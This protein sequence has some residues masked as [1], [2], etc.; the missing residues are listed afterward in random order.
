MEVVLKQTD[1]RGSVIIL[2]DDGWEYHLV[3]TF[4]GKLRGG[5]IH[6]EG[7]WNHVVK[8]DVKFIFQYDK[9]VE[10][11]YH[12]GDVMQIPAGVPHMSQSLTD[13]VVLEWHKAG[14]K[15][16]YYE[17]FREKVRNQ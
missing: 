4:A 5:E 6:N 2:E 3:K 7:Q 10:L 17:P 12:Q 11:I 8:G 14:R 1:E 16:E 13:S 15:T 9:T